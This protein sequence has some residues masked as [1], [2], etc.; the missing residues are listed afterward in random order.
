MSSKRS[1]KF[2]KVSEEPVGW[3]IAPNQLLVL[4][5][6]LLRVVERCH[7]LNGSSYLL[8]FVLQMSQPG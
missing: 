7:E 4:L 6:M 5:L 3:W 2:S 8:T 1:V